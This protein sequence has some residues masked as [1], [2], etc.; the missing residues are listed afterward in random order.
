MKIIFLDSSKADLR[1]FKH[2]YIGHFPEGR[3][4][5][6]AHFLKTKELLS[7]NPYIGHKVE[8]MAGVR[9]HSVTRTPFAFIYRV[10]EDAIEVLR[11]LDSRA[12]ES[13]DL[14]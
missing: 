13:N 6:D 4:N 2:Y 14:I 12:E 7:S 5:A 11:V 9:V 3:Q 8:G 10:T 1:W